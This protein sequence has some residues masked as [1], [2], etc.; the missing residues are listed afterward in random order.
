MN[1]SMMLKNFR[2]AFLFGLFFESL[3]IYTPICKILYDYYLDENSVRKATIR[4]LE[5][6]R[7]ENENLKERKRY[8]EKKENEK[9]VQ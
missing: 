3:I 8:R 6:K 1:K 7:I 4:R 2:N 9:S 5:V